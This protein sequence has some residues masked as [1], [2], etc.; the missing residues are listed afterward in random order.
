MSKSTRNK[1][2]EIHVLVVIIIGILIFTYLAWQGSLEPP[3]KEAIQSF[4]DVPP[5][6]WAY[7]EIE[8]IYSYGI[9]V[10]CSYDPPLYCPDRSPT[11]AEMAVFGARIIELIKYRRMK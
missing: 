7:D 5:N 6:Y 8:L 3:A 1:I 9:T 11:R 2:I 10:G 4:D